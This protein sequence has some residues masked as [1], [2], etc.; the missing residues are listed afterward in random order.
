MHSAASTIQPKLQVLL[1]TCETWLAELLGDTHSDRTEDL[2][3]KYREID[4][5]LVDDVQILT[6]RPITQQVFSSFL[7]SLSMEGTRVALAHSGV[8]ADIPCMAM[9][10]P[11]GLV[12]EIRPPTTE[13]MISILARK[14]PKISLDV[15]RAACNDPYGDIR[16]AEGRLNSFLLKNKTKNLT[17]VYRSQQL[18]SGR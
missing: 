7:A 5:L 3:A 1:I 13:E 14:F 17:P 18:S 2:C 9:A 12:V 4:L 8:L 16:C 6:G 10:R 11:S 15:V